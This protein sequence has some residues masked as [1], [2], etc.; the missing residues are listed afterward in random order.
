MKLCEPHN[1]ILTQCRECGIGSSIC[2]HHRRKSTCSIC[3][4]IQHLQSIINRRI[5]NSLKAG[6]FR[7]TEKDNFYTKC[8]TEEFAKH[9]ESKFLQN[10]TWANHGQWHI[11]HILPLGES[12]LGQKITEDELIK[13][14]HYMNTQPLWA[15]DNILKSNRCPNI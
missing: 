10:M 3:K 4:P 11:D 14:L 1:K 2:R 15:I 5:H 6:N 13:R 12:P 7:K 8:T 9:I